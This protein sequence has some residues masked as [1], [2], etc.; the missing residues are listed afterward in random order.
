MVSID[1]EGSCSHLSDERCTHMDENYTPHTDEP[2][3][4]LIFRLYKADMI[5][6]NV[7]V[8]IDMVNKVERMDTEEFLSQYRPMLKIKYKNKKKRQAME[9]KLR[10]RKNNIRKEY[11]DFFKKNLGKEADAAKLN[12][13]SIVN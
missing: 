6:L 10:D 7:D 4:N 3:Y 2:I 9:N 8:I 11:A 1:K 5:K 13:N 12:G